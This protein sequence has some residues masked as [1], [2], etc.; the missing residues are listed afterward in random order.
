MSGFE[1]LGYDDGDWIQS[2]IDWGMIAQDTVSWR[3]LFSSS[4]NNAQHSETGKIS[5]LHS[6]QSHVLLQCTFVVC[7]RIGPD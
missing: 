7:R 3:Q 4:M 6:A 1:G 5:R 2:W